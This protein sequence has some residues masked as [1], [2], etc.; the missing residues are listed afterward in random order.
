MNPLDE[1]SIWLKPTSESFLKLKNLIGKIAE[2]TD[3][4]VFEPHVTLVGGIKN[5]QES[6][7]NILRSIRPYTIP[8]YLTLDSVGIS[9]SYYKSLFLHCTN[10]E[11]LNELRKT[12]AEAFSSTGIFEPH[13]SLL[14]SNLSADIKEKIIE[15]Y[16]ITQILPLSIEIQD[17]E[18]WHAHGT[19]DLWRKIYT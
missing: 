7:L 2:E 17:L 11:P 8:L 10:S 3:S 6:V 15:K 4:P 19:P 1:Y 14:Y 12:Y 5:D 16:S 13:L 18:L 9:D